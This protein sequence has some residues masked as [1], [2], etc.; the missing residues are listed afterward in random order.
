M[1]YN[2]QQYVTER[3]SSCTGQNPRYL[4]G[5]CLFAAF[6]G[7]GFIQL[8]PPK[9]NDTVD[10]TKVENALKLFEGTKMRG[11]IIR[12]QWAKED[13]LTR[14]Q[15]EWKQQ[16]Q[17]AT[18][19]SYHNNL[20]AGGQ[21]D[22]TLVK[23]TYFRL[24]KRK[25][26]PILKVSSTPEELTVQGLSGDVAS[27]RRKDS[28]DGAM[29]KPTRFI[30][31]EDT[32]QRKPNTDIEAKHGM[33]YVSSG[34]E[35]S[36]AEQ[37]GG[38]K[39][40]GPMVENTVKKQLSEQQ[41]K[42]AQQQRA[43]EL[44]LR[45]KSIQES[46]RKSTVSGSGPS[47]H[48][49]FTEQGQTLRY[50]G[51][52]SEAD[53]EDSKNRQSENDIQDMEDRNGQKPMKLFDDDDDDDDNSLQSGQD[54]AASLLEGISA[55]HNDEFQENEAGEIDTATRRELQRIRWK[56]G[57]T[58][59]RFRLDERFVDPD[60]VATRDA[61]EMENDA[62]DKTDE[63]EEN[64]QELQSNQTEETNQK[65]NVAELFST[66]EAKSA[67]EKESEQGLKILSELLNEKIESSASLQSS[68]L[69]KDDD[70]LA[71]QKTKNKDSEEQRKA[72]H[73]AKKLDQLESD[74]RAKETISR[75]K[76]GLTSNVPLKGSKAVVARLL[77]N[78]TGEPDVNNKDNLENNLWAKKTGQSKAGPMRFDP[79]KASASALVAPNQPDDDSVEESGDVHDFHEN[80]D[81]PARSAQSYDQS[82]ATK[83]AISTKDNNEKEERFWNVNVKWSQYKESSVPI[84]KRPSETVNTGENANSFS[85]GF[86]LGG[87]PLP[88]TE[89]NTP[90]QQTSVC[91]TKH[92]QSSF[93]FN[94]NLED[95]DEQPTVEREREQSHDIQKLPAFGGGEFDEDLE[96]NTQNGGIGENGLGKGLQYVPSSLSKAVERATGSTGLLMTGF[97]FTKNKKKNREV[98]SSNHETEQTS[99]WVARRRQ[100]TKDFKRKLRQTK[101]VSRG[102]T[103]DF[104]GK[105]GYSTAM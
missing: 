80:Q 58:D 73:Q 16:T 68:K 20:D 61:V 42:L 69:Q 2:Y 7:F 30:F 64:D 47:E 89:A 38:K 67:L 72:V 104:V 55:S 65:I 39:K 98:S 51:C 102:S 88:D 78:A 77:A 60:D 6:K 63:K 33:G 62:V 46:L 25:G 101:R 9:E 90:L 43:E 18:Q 91:Q 4:F 31:L 15:K 70:S 22:E 97:A 84:R 28:G 32:E 37:E 23:R 11:G 36:A 99:A 12:F 56:Y 66:A 74:M 75:A 54:H 93:G 92:Q 94:F 13:Y 24:R 3:A 59:P 71:L 29:G 41:R 5:F 8:R 82:S 21:S 105:A 50:L 57:V 40:D 95:R 1:R 52:E 96:D 45:R 103:A 100:L 26:D 34:E 14:L 48:L 17:R 49:A 35:S 53:S 87:N 81:I 79:S 27:K 10:A 19:K 85:F 83:R 44:K 86:Q 76:A